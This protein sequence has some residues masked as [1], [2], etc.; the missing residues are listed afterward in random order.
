[1]ASKVCLSSSMRLKSVAAN[2][3][4]LRSEYTARSC[5][6]CF[7]LI[8]EGSLTSCPRIVMNFASFK[9]SNSWSCVFVN[10]GDTQFIV[11]FL[12]KPFTEQQPQDEDEHQWHD[13]QEKQRQ[14]IANQ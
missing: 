1:M 11:R 3:L 10:D 4:F 8:E 12:A 5:C 7:G 14:A 6:I 2:G 9:R 13:Q